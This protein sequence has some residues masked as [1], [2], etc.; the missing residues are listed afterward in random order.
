M[1]SDCVSP[2][3][4]LLLDGVI[5]YAYILTASFCLAEFNNCYL[6]G[7]ETAGEK[8]QSIRTGEQN[9]EVSEHV[10]NKML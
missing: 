10:Q 7:R 9:A 5:A 2:S 8:M 1:D 3:K 6:Q 4:R